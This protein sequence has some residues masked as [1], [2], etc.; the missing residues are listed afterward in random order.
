MN[1]S[2]CDRKFARANSLSDS[3]DRPSP[4]KLLKYLDIHL[5]EDAYTHYVLV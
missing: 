5:F 3:N 2:A 4:E 1:M